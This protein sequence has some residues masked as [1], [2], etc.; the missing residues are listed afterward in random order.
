MRESLRVGFV[1][2]LTGLGIVVPVTI[3]LEL[4]KVSFISIFF[5]IGLFLSSVVAYWVYCLTKKEEDEKAVKDEEAVMSISQMACAQ[6]QAK[7]FKESVLPYYKMHDKWV[8]NVEDV[9]RLISGKLPLDVLIHRYRDYDAS[10]PKMEKIEIGVSVGIGDIKFFYVEEFR[11]N[12]KAT[13]DEK[14]DMGRLRYVYY[15]EGYRKVVKY[16]KL[17][18]VLYLYSSDKRESF[19]L[20]WFRQEDNRLIVDGVIKLINGEPCKSQLEMCS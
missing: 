4:L 10:Y 19:Y 2:F 6:E 13:F 8:N 17:C 15:S 7:R 18:V 14:V 20:S 16:D 5:T 9:M 3:F 1:A 11:L 12:E